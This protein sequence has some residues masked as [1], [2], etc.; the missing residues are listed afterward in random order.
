[1]TKGKR[2]VTVDADALNELFTCA[3]AWLVVIAL[4]NPKETLALE[5]RTENALNAV[6]SD[7]GDL[8][9]EITMDTTNATRC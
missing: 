7:T 6:R 9:R 5:R 2:R 4:V 3:V 8:F 1:M